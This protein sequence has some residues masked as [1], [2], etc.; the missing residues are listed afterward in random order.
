ML[1]QL[2]KPYAVLLFDHQVHSVIPSSTRPSILL[3][4]GAILTADI[5]IGADGIHS[6]VRKSITGINSCA[7]PTGDAA[8]RLTIPTPKMRDDPD[9]WALV[10]HPQYLCWMG[11]YRHIVGYCIA[12]ATFYYADHQSKIH[13]RARNRNI[14][15]S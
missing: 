2:S 6:V 7:V 5:V 10:D 3:Q 8:Y 9:L 15:L 1:Y 4:S 14:T 12:S 13:G 11:P